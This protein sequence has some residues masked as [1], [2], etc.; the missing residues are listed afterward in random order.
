[1]KAQIRAKTRNRGR[2]WA[3][4]HRPDVKNDVRGPSRGDGWRCSK[5][6]RSRTNEL[7]GDVVGTANVRR[8]GERRG[9]P[10]CSATLH[11]AALMELGPMLPA[12]QQCGAVDNGVAQ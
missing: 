12:W 11:G 8:R 7:A 10:Q 1:M 9:S 3:E 4:Y 2:G 5:Q 6:D